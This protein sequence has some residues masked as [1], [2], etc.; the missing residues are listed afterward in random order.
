MK[1]LIAFT[2]LCLI[3]SGCAGQPATP[4]ITPTNGGLIVSPTPTETPLAITSTP[5]SVTPTAVPATQTG[6]PASGKVPDFAHIILIVL[7]NRDYQAVIGNPSMPYLNTLAKQNVLLTNSFAVRHPSLPNYLALVS[8]STQ[9]ITSDC[10]NCFVDQP[11]L[12]DFI[13]ASG[14]TWKTYQEDLPSPCY[15][16]NATPYFQKHNPFIYFDSIRLNAERC[17]RSIV[18]L[19]NLTADL[20]ANQLPNFAFIMPNIC[21]SGHDCPPETADG[22]LKG[23]L[24]RLQASPAI[25]TNSLIIVTFDEGAETSTGSCCGLAKGG[26]Q[27]ATILVS[28]LAKPAFNDPTPYSHYSVLKTILKAWNLPD[29]ANTQLP[30]TQPIEAPWNTQQGSTGGSTSLVTSSFRPQ[31]VANC[32]DGAPPSG[33]YSFNLCLSDPAEGATL[34]GNVTITATFKLSSPSTNIPLDP[35][36]AGIQRM[37]FYLDGAYLLSDFQ[38]PFTFTLPTEKWVNISHTLSAEA[39]M[40]DGFVSPQ[41]SLTL[42]FNNETG[43]LP[44]PAQFQPSVGSAR[45]N[46]APLLVAAAGDGASGEAN[47]GKVSDLIASLNPNLFL[48]LGDVYERGSLAEFSNWYGSQASNGFGRFRSITNPTIGN[49]EYLT[50]GA[51]GY[52]DYWGN[53]PDY[54]SYNAGGWHFISL[55]SNAAIVPVG[56]DSVQYHWF[57]EDL[58]LHA[59]VC[60]IVYYHHPLFDIGPEG[61]TTQMFDMW[62]LM[63]KYGVSIV[64]N[65]HDHDYQRWKALDGD[66]QLSPTGITEFVAGASGHGLQTITGSDQRVAYSSDINPTAFGVLLLQLNQDGASFSYHNIDG[67]VLDSGV[68]PCTKNP[69]DIQPPRTP[70]ALTA[71]SASDKNV[72]LTWTA[73]SDNTGVSGYTIYR[74]GSILTN[75]SGASLAY[76][77]TTIQPNTSYAYSVAAFDPTGNRS[78]ISAPIQVTTLPDSTTPVQVPTPTQVSTPAVSNPTTLVFPA[79]A[80][81]YVNAAN[82]GTNYG[83]TST[84]RVDTSPDLH[85]YL[86]FDLRKL[87]GKSI[88]QARLKIYANSDSSMGINIL[89]VA[90]NN[91]GEFTLT[92][93]AAPAFGPELVS[94][95]RF[96]SGDWIILDVTKYINGDGLLSFGISAVDSTAVSLASR[97]MGPNAPELLIDLR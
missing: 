10:I 69:A 32:V 66:G 48:Y 11:N 57:A 54:Y 26:G 90:D 35:G 94:S 13:E 56:P 62:K 3:L 84:L 33:A 64:L 58:L 47:A 31:N 91:W 80:D 79:V 43:S 12:G 50:Q 61:P 14:R 42:N 51:S 38:S 93:S 29:L 49:H 39:Q 30:G 59:Q 74:N 97:E 95:G 89:A 83:R 37:V 28:P 46:G 7:E 18:P 21:N 86:R 75:V 70:G 71:V 4:D 63:A 73:S 8:G 68:I 45:A 34:S 65:G 55:D 24:T 72:E 40:R 85:G 60:T 25:G 77:D 81:T 27:I 5:L 20:A 22:W 1:K 87:G 19:T 76:T 9:N 52:F 36:K 41:A 17:Q 88:A 6:Q 78:P 23:M 53:I 82:P 15:V 2:I 96:K 16:G 44:S 92:Y 67:T